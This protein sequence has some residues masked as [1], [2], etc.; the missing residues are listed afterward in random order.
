MTTTLNHPLRDM[1]TAQI[2]TMLTGGAIDGQAL[3]D[4]L[5]GDLYALTDAPASTDTEIT[6]A[7]LLA[8][9]LRRAAAPPPKRQDAT[10][11]NIA[12]ILRPYAADEQE[13]MFVFTLDNRRPTPGIIGAY[14]VYKGARS[15]IIIS[16]PDIL[17]PAIR[18]GATRFIL[19]HTHPTDEARQSMDDIQATGILVELAG[20]MEIHFMDHIIVSRQG[21][22]SMAEQ[23]AM[24]KQ[25]AAPVS[26]EDETESPQYVEGLFLAD[27]IVDAEEVDLTEEQLRAYRPE[28]LYQWLQNWGYAWDDALESWFKVEEAEQP[29]AKAPF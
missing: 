7:D 24:K 1:P 5:Q 29:T 6:A 13:H 28:E 19:A 27:G 10:H 8:E 20:M 21:F 22:F 18:D 17:R 12:R 3:M 14:L 9:L 26:G 4:E 16:P 23:G 2:I 11:A 15:S 25:E